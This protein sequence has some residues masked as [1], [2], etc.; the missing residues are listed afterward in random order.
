MF[1]NAAKKLL[2][3]SRIVLCVGIG[4]SLLIAVP[5]IIKGADTYN[6][7]EAWSLVFDG[8]EVLFGGVLAAAVAA[9][10][11]YGLGHI[12]EK[13]EAINNSISQIKDS[14]ICRSCGRINKEGSEFCTKCG[15]S[16]KKENE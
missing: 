13:T 2:L 4:A 6:S 10:V 5:M 3:C 14:C 8:I 9:T 16:L 7:K 1:K 12:C 11:L 15:K